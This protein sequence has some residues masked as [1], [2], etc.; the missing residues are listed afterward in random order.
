MK[1]L[2]LS[3]IFTSLCATAYAAEQSPALDDKNAKI[4]YSVGYQIGGDFKYQEIEIRPNAMLQG[5]RD[6]L[7]GRQ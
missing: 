4:N 7:S 5:I 2:Y 1:P 6:A 3:I